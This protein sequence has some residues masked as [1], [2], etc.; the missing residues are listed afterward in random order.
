MSEITWSFNEQSLGEETRE[1]CPDPGEFTW[2]NVSGTEMLLSNVDRADS[3][4]DH[5]R[6]VNAAAQV[7]LEGLSGRRPFAQVSG[8]LPPRTV[9]RLQLLANNGTWS[10]AKIQRTMGMETTPGTIQAVVLINNAARITAATLRL[11]ADKTGWRCER[12]HLVWAG[13]YLGVG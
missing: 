13:S 4:E 1:C 8:W 11:R 7:L 9:T 10:N 6:L 3:A 2:D 12:A 5:Q